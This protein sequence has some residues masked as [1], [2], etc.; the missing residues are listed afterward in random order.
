M[1]WFHSQPGGHL[2]AAC[3]SA[4]CRVPQL[5]I[6]LPFSCLQTVGWWLDRQGRH[7]QELILGWMSQF[8]LEPSQWQGTAPSPIPFPPT[9]QSQTA[10][11]GASFGEPRTRDSPIGSSIEIPFS[12]LYWAPPGSC[13]SI[14]REVAPTPP[15]LGMRRNCSPINPQELWAFLQLAKHLVEQ[16]NTS[17]TSILSEKLSYFCPH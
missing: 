2:S 12:Q 14:Y 8:S 6:I 15:V 13:I 5:K 1:S 4:W 7:S 10:C 3:C 17:P 11:H 16:S 9:P